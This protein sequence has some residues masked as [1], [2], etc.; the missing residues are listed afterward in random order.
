MLCKKEFNW[1]PMPEARRF[2][3]A[4][5][6][7]VTGCADFP[8]TRAVTSA[9]RHVLLGIV[10]LLVGCGPLWAQGTPPPAPATIPIP[11]IAE[12]SER[13][14][15]ELRALE[16]R[17]GPSEALATIA[18]KLP[19]A[20]RRAAELQAATGRVA[21]G[22][23]PPDIAADLTIKGRAL[24]AQF[25]DWQGTLTTEATKR[26][27]DMRAL[28]ETTQVWEVTAA[29]ARAADAPA[30][31]ISRID[32]TLA[33]L[34]QVQGRVASRRAEALTLQEQVVRERGRAQ[35]SLDA[36]A[37]ARQSTAWRTFLP[38][39]PPIWNPV[40]RWQGWRDVVARAGENLQENRRQL[41][42]YLTDYG[43]HLLQHVLFFAC[44]LAVLVHGR[45]RSRQWSVQD[46]ARERVRV[47]Y[48]RPVSAGIVASLAMVWWIQP[49]APRVVLI[50][51][52]CVALVPLVR[53]ANGLTPRALHPVIV[54]IALFFPVERFREAVVRDPGIEQIA[55]LLASIAF[56]AIAIVAARR[57]EEALATPKAHR[58][59][60]VIRM[61]AL[62]LLAAAVVG[63]ALGFTQL[64]QAMY[65][66]VVRSAGVALPLWE[67]YW[68][69]DAVM[70]DGLR[71]WP[72][73]LLQMVRR[74][75]SLL[76]RR[77]EVV[78]RWVL[79]GVWLWFT[80]RM[81]GLDG[82]VSSMVQNA[83]TAT[84]AYREFRVSLA[85]VVALAVAIWST[86]ALSRFVRFVLDEDVF[87]RLQLELGLPNA[88]SVLVNYLILLV[89]FLVALAMVGIDLTRL[90]ILAGAVGIGIGFGLQNVINNFV[91]GFI[92]LF[93]RPIRIGDRLQLDNIT[94][95]IRRIGLR[96]ST[97]RTWEGAELIIPNAQL[98]S[99]IVTNWTLSDRQRRID[100]PVGVAYGTPPRQVLDLL[101]KV[102]GQHVMVL[103]KPEPVA[104]FLGF[105]DS[106]LNFELRVFTDQLERLLQTRSELNLAVHDAL[107]GAGITIP[108]PQRDVHLPGAVPAACRASVS[109]PGEAPCGDGTGST[110]SP[111]KG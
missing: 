77:G 71:S 42:A 29:Q 82:M 90:T 20:A 49:H 35:E 66:G 52:T 64:A 63:S 106:S 44:A 11:E 87:P 96:S 102:A 58:L 70:A 41:D 13:V 61:I 27:E 16:K 69:A 108:F 110:K 88:L 15:G 101:L 18:A 38:D 99:S 79:V 21:T 73:D 94:G 9:A 84:L 105:G 92:L 85:D 6:V 59:A 55:L 3:L 68:V 57:V 8:G 83:F 5:S 81:L 78:V 56:T 32:E 103:A 111:T 24:R 107:A 34:R 7:A 19:E 109:E 100:V 80:L 14:A 45:A 60:V 86:F 43:A 28:A 17:L 31:L 53:I 104:L 37:Q 26:E 72:L 75:R 93:E 12:A 62:P 54:A 46:P 2:D 74:H 91:S 22:P 67:S 33:R 30:S 4:L 23:V 89:G 1:L 48:A 25:S 40:S 50:V 39:S 98:T 76:E 65:S 51:L 10:A 97:M 47:I 95:E 36:F